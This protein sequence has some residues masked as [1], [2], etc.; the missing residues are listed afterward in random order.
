LLSSFCSSEDLPLK[1]SSANTLAAEAPITAPIIRTIEE[2]SRVFE[3]KFIYFL[4]SVL[5]NMRYG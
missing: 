2:I 4:E 3:S 1:G 5:I